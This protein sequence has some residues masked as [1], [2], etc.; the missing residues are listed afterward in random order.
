M[1]DPD[2]PESNTAAVGRTNALYHLAQIVHGAGGAN[3]L[4]LRATTG[5]QILHLA[6]ETGRFQRALGNQNEPVSL[7]RLFNKV[8]SPALDGSNGRFHATMAGD[9][10]NRQFR[11]LLLDNRKQGKPVKART[12]QPDIKKD[13]GRAP[14]LDQLQRLIA[15]RS[16]ARVIALIFQ[17]PCNKLTNIDLVVD[18]ENISS[19]LQTSVSPFVLSDNAKPEL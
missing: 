16:H 12:L 8:I 18:Y 6:L 2:W 19:H 9:H 7:E 13:Q 4:C 3:K 11:V 1:P 15:V 14:L 10:D 5:L 17:K